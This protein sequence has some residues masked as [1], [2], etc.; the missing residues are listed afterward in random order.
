MGDFRRVFRVSEGIRSKSINKARNG[1]LGGFVGGIL[2]GFVF[3]YLRILLPGNIYA[4]LTGLVVLGLLI[5][6]FYGLIEINLSKS[7]PRAPQR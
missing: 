3:E 6:V 4:R 5:G 7:V 2:G 1:I